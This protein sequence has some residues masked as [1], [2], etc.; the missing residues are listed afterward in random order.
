MK[1]IGKDT[2]ENS[3]LN[4]YSYQKKHLNL[5]S[6]HASID[7]VHTQLKKDGYFTSITES[8]TQKEKTIIA[9][10]SLGPKTEKVVI[11]ISKKLKEEYRGSLFTSRDSTSLRPSEVENY[12]NTIAKELDEQGKSFAEIT[13]EVPKQVK[14]SFIFHLSI[15]SSKTR[16]V[17]NIVVKGYD[18]FPKFYLKN[19]YKISSK[20]I[21]SKERLQIISNQTKALSFLEEIKPPE[22]LFKK[23]S[24]ILY[25]FLKQKKISSI[26]G[27]INFATKDNSNDL[28]INGNL[29]LK[30]HNVL[31]TGESFKL[32]WNRI[33]D[34]NSEFRL[35]TR[36][37]YIFRS[38]ITPSFSFNIYRQDSTFL[39]TKVNLSL[40]YRINAK[41]DISTSFS[42]ENSNYLLDDAN[43]DIKDFSNY[44]VGLGYSFILRSQNTFYN[45]KL[46]FQIN[47]S[48]GSRDENNSSSTTQ[49][50][51]ESSTTLNI[52][53]SKRSY[54]HIKNRLGYLNS[55]NFL[56]NELFRI[57]G[58]NSL[59][60]FNEQSIFTDQYTYFNTEYRYLV[61]NSSYLYTIGD[62]VFFNETLSDKIR[63]AIGIGVGYSFQLNNNFINLGYAIGK[64]SGSAFDFNNSKLIISWNTFF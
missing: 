38:A 41:S 6:V 22:V 40:N 48:F 52:L 34:E 37:P 50:K 28:L 8:I 30:L 58:A 21:F 64:A 43:S 27:I 56:L 63:N 45:N 12:I 57:G 51:V 62:V 4:R 24:T 60:G 55:K 15:K 33:K 44:F 9:K 61:S 13:L 10:F 49:Y 25:L 29:D 46:S 23:D 7:S 20:T 47:S 18:Q 26:D 2:V 36:I 1:I 59:R 32:F 54:L 42:S 19:H 3:L 31:H 53:T 11:V 39:N 16:T 35:S 14:S 17:N 5:K